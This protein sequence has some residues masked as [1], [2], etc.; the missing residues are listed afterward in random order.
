MV[1]QRKLS[2]KDMQQWNLQQ[3]LITCFLDCDIIISLYVTRIQTVVGN[4]QEKNTREKG[5]AVSVLLP[6]TN[7]IEDRQQN[8]QSVIQ[9]RPIRLRVATTGASGHRAAGRVIAYTCCRHSVWSVALPPWITHVIHRSLS[10][11][12]D[13]AKLRP[14]KFT[15]G[16]A[17]V[18]Y[19]SRTL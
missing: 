13:G 7:E 6:L 14:R 10:Q 18:C 8:V 5:L 17:T 3:D 9:V 1:H 15:T 12:T 2:V 16:G 11:R 4:W 19:R